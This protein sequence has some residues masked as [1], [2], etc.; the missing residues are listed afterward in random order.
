MNIVLIK[1]YVDDDIFYIIKWDGR[2]YRTTD[3]REAKKMFRKI[4]RFC[5]S[6]ERLVYGF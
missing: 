3:K 1:K 4:K 2:E 6:V 5:K